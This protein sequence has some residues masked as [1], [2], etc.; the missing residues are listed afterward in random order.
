LGVPYLDYKAKVVEDEIDVLGKPGIID[1]S[2]Y[3]RAKARGVDVTEVRVLV[4]EDL[5]HFPP[6]ATFVFCGD[7]LWYAKYPAAPAETTPEQLASRYGKPRT[8]T[9]GLRAGHI[10]YAVKVCGYPEKGLAFTDVHGERI[11]NKFVFP[12]FAELPFGLR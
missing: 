12:P 5:G 7:K 6:V 11:E 1:R 10:L 3:A 8:A 2:V 4:W 9:L